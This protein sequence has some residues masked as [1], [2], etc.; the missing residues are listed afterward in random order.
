MESNSVNFLGISTLIG[1]RKVKTFINLM[2]DQ[3]IGLG[4]FLEN[5]DLSII[6]VGTRIDCVLIPCF[7]RRSLLL[8]IDEKS[9]H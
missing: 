4:D 9:S 3:P 7:N 1:V 6:R 5:G 8:D 2:R